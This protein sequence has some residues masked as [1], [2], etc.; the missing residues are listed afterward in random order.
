[1]ALKLRDLYPATDRARVDAKVTTAFI[2][3]LVEQVTTGFRGDVGVVPRQFLRAFVNH[4][5]LVDEHPDYDPMAASGFSPAAL[6]PE[7]EHAL[8]GTSYELDADDALVPR[9]DVW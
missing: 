5:D 4:L 6:T 7:E 8:A 9:E 2:E 1:V 3:R